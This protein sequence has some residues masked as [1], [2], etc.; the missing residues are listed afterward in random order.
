MLNSELSMV[1]GLI[2]L[3]IPLCKMTLRYQYSIITCMRFILRNCRTCSDA[4]SR[5]MLGHT[6]LIFSSFQSHQTCDIYSLKLGQCWTSVEYRGD[7]VPLNKHWVNV[8]SS[9]WGRPTSDMNKLI[10]HLNSQRMLIK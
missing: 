8:L 9:R 5:V 3:Y 4:R 2:G 1:K 6:N 10:L 7:G